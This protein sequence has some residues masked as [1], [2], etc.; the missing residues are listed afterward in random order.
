MEM[1][2]LPVNQIEQKRIHNMVNQLDKVLDVLYESD[3]CKEV[4]HSYHPLLRRILQLKMENYICNLKE[5]IIKFNS[6]LKNYCLLISR[7]MIILLRILP[8]Q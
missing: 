4:V 7:S 6:L 8:V 1:M 2:N 5:N 3:V